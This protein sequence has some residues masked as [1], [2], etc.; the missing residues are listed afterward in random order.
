M[1]LRCDLQGFRI[2]QWLLPKQPGLAETH[3]GLSRQWPD[4]EDSARAPAGPTGLSNTRGFSQN[5]SQRMHIRLDLS[6]RLL[7][8]SEK[9]RPPADPRA[10]H[11]VTGYAEERGWHW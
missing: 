10:L 3:R 5:N 8:H 11:T 6:R 7:E 4:C 2:C 9:L 1:Q